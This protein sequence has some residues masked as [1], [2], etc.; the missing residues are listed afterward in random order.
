ML[1]I[2]QLLRNKAVRPTPIRT[3]ILSLLMQTKRAYAHADLERAFDFSLDRVS[4]Y[5]SLLTLSEAGL[6]HKHIDAKGTCSYFYAP[7]DIMPVDKSADTV[8]LNQNEATN[9]T[10]YPH[11]KCSNCETV[12]ALPKLPP[13][14]L[15]LVR[16]YQLDNLRLLAEGTC[17]DCRHHV[18]PLII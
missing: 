6:I 10:G 13:E 5:R 2:E 15:A 9:P 1:T 16:Q 17:D 11:F 18:E 8:V 3:G 12:V 14:Y 4:I 7:L